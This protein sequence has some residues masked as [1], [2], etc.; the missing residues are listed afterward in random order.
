MSQHKKNQTECT[1]PGCTSSLSSFDRRSFMSR[2][3]GIG[4]GL[5]SM[6]GM[7]AFSSLAG[8]DEQSANGDYPDRYYI[9]CYFSGGWDILLSLDPRDPAV[10]TN[11]AS[12]TTQIQ[13]G[14]ENLNP[15]MAGNGLVYTPSM[16]LGGFIGDL[17]EW[18]DRMVVVRGMSME[19]L[20]HEVGRRRFLTGRP[21]AGL[22]ARGSSTDTWLSSQLG[23][24][25]PIPNLSV[26]VESYN[27]GLPDFASS[28]RTAN[29]NDLIRALEPGSPN[30]GD[31]L[32]QQIDDFLASVAECPTAE[33]SDVWQAAEIGRGKSIEMVDQGLDDLF[34]FTA[35]TPQM[36]AIKERYTG[37]P[38]Q[39]LN[40]E[41]TSTAMA[42]TA[43]MSGVARCV[44]IRPCPGLDTHFNNWERDQGPNQRRGFNAIASMVK[45]LYETPFKDT[46]DN[47]LD[48]TTIVGFSEFSR[49]PLLN[50]NG[51]RDHWLGNSCFLLG[52]GIKGGKA[53][54]ASSNFGMNP[55]TVDLNTGLL[56]PDGEVIRPEH[57][58]ATLLDEVGMDI[59]GTG[60][61]L[62]VDPLRALFT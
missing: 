20:T 62:R 53:I 22:L 30:Y 5:A 19:T 49:T 35:N 9:F 37:N 56:D 15:M 27:K 24:N 16:I 57:I 31:L 46:G 55:Q 36:Q 39:N 41:Q 47:W 34:R 10:F 58:I 29:V 1:D 12:T 25:E 26:G 42:A 50:V 59:S 6:G 60:A 13:C 17:R 33:L 28:L 38:S 7:G 4:L 45:H 43:V 23:T 48:H 2:S 21:P 51:G 54:G 8:A 44:S 3:A 40:A 61:D 32:N 14:Y 52:G 18:H 11:Q